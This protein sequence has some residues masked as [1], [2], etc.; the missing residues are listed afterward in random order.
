MHL[1]YLVIPI[2]AIISGILILV[3]PKAFHYVV[4]FFLI[5]Y[6]LN[7]VFGLSHLLPH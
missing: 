2:L 7:A 5:I 1:H 3:F 6:G 4:A